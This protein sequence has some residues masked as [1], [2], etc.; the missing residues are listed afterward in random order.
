MNLNNVDI[1]GLPADVRKTFRQLQVLHAEKRIQN[2][3]V[4]L[5]LNNDLH[6]FGRLMN[7]SWQEKKLLS[8]AITND[9]IDIQLVFLRIECSKNITYIL[10]NL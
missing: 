7:E 9:K 2:K 4:R 5:I 10:F 6:N 1:S 8:K 3:S